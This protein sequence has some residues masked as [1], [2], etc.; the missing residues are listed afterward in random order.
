MMRLEALREQVC[1]ANQRLVGERLVTLTWGNVSG[2]DVD[3]GLV[4]IKPSGVGYAELTPAAI[5][6]VDLEGETVEGA[7][8][9]SS[10]TPTHVL[11]YQHFRERGADVAGITHT[12]SPKA[13]AFAQARRAIPCLGTT[14]ADHFHGPVPVTRPLSAEE[15]ERAY[16]ANTGRV[17]VEATADLDPAAMPGV[18]V[19]G[20][21][22]FAWGKSAN[23]SVD[24]AVA[25]EAVAAM[26]LDTAALTHD[27]APPLLEDHVLDKHHRRKHGPDA[28]YGQAR[29]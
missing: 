15:V 6:L 18:L 1:R 16:E 22:P 14:H 23:H 27:Q 7:L 29:S 20:H 8:R 24:N 10:D 5:V 3:S 21:A 19:A 28:Y 17:I 26:N 25:L 13:T 12:H 9:P 11:L 2:F 4:A